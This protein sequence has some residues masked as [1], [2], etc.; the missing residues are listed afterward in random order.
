MKR[1]LVKMM[2]MLLLAVMVVSLIATNVFADEF[3][4]IIDDIN[5][6]KDTTGTDDSM[7]NMLGAI[8]T[9]TR[10]VAVG[11]AVI[12]LLVLAIKYISA[13][14]GD[15]AEIKKHAT[16]YVIGAVVLFA[17]SGILKIIELFAQ[18]V[19]PAA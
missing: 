13:A 3:D 10:T 4:G 7:K 9:V 8:L 19:Q 1:S 15:K 17:A 14:P 18:N 11:V 6:R 12:M 2:A 16:V 5:G